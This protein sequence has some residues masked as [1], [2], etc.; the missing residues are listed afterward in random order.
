MHT[1][2][3]LRI[4]VLL[5]IILQ[6]GSG[7]QVFGKPTFPQAQTYFISSSLGDDSND[8]LSESSPFASINKVN[9]L[10][11]NPGDQI[12]LKCGDTW[13]AEQLVLRWSGTESAP[14]RFSSYPANCPDQPILSGSRPLTGWIPF[15]SLPDAE[16]YQ[17]TLPPGDFLLGINQLF[18][19]GQRLTLGRWPNLDAPHGGYSFV[20]EHLAKE[21]GDDGL[22]GGFDWSGAVVHLKNMRDSIVNR[23]VD[24]SD[25]ITL[26]LNKKIYC[27]ITNEGDCV[28]WGYFINNHLATLDQDGEWYYDPAGRKVYLVSLSGTPEGI[29]ASVILDDSLPVRFG[30]IKLSDG[31]T[32]AYLILENL[33][34]KNWFN[35]GIDTPQSMSSDIYHHLTLR[36]L[37][38]QDVDSAAVLLSTSLENPSDGYSGLRGGHH[39]IFE[40]NVIDGANHFGVSGYL[41][42][43]TLTGNL[44]QNIGL[45]E[46]L[47]Q[48]GMG[49]GQAGDECPEYGNGLHIQVDDLQVSGFGNLLQDNRFEKIGNNAVNILG[50]QNILVRNLITQACLAKADCAGLRVLSSHILEES[51]AYEVQLIDNIIE[52]IPGNS[53]GCHESF[54]P[55][56]L[57][58][59]V[60]NFA[61]DI[62]VSGNTVISTTAAGIQF[63]RATGNVQDNTVYNAAA[64]ILPD[65]QLS[66]LS[67]FTPVEVSA[68]GNILYGL[69]PQAATLHTSSLDDL[70]TSDFN[71][72]FQPYVEDHITYGENWNGYTLSEWQTFSGF[73]PFSKTNWFRLNPGDAPRSRIFYNDS[74]STRV[75]DLGGNLY[76]D[77]DRT[78]VAGTITLAPFKSQI[79]IENGEV[80]LALFRLEPDG[81][82]V[83]E[84][85]DFILDLTGAGFTANSEVHWNGSSRT[86]SFVSGNRLHAQISAADVSS[87]GNITV[88]VYEPSASPSESAPLTF[89]VVKY[90]YSIY[91][92]VAVK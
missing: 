7:S 42:E 64:G 63:R 41:S 39:L 40:N 57:G 69:N 77:L 25:G 47:G 34:V 74:P 62:E 67:E 66:L 11:L 61:S 52:D 5:G 76:L 13:R 89:R 3:I 54:A 37:T 8:G 48:S 32:T 60:D 84:A 55:S 21:I 38:I 33:A 80:G 15:A 70:I 56:G 28:G 44:F 65:A 71:Y 58:I 17:V 9:G 23:H 91:L 73:D 36:N 26:T 50:P 22:P 16:I 81:W 83:D 82:L 86:T 10:A 85:E 53:D 31:S 35:H 1:K 14:I 2:K 59:Y 18:R 75:V 29:E 72:L 20:D 87:I 49:C 6:F 4:L 79:L 68:T 19:D 27:V 45:L 51:D 90:P 78:E 92:P 24:A 46:N 12:L 88:T 30:G 43:S